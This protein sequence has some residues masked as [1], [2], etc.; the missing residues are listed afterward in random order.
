MK[1]S[2]TLC[3]TA[4]CRSALFHLCSDIPWVNGVTRTAPIPFHHNPPTPRW[5]LLHMESH[6][7]LL[8][9]L[10]T[11]RLVQKYFHLCLSPTE[12][13]TCNC[14]LLGFILLW[15]RSS[16]IGKKHLFHL[17]FVQ[18]LITLSTLFFTETV[19]KQ[20]QYRESFNAPILD[21]KPVL[22]LRRKQLMSLM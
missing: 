17:N 7:Q 11:K 13:R 19:L 22:H 4:V 12:T 6:L 9:S 14:R 21:I 15:R 1:L 8:K 2:P 5:V 20:S 18:F 3:S 16:L 10:L